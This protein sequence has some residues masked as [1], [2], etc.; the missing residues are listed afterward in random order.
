M[1]NNECLVVAKL[2][3]GLG[4]ELPSGPPTS[5][6]LAALHLLCVRPKILLR[7]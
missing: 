2:L 6:I 7:N 5:L 1:V 3:P 4:N